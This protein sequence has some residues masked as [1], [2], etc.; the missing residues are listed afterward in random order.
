MM[1]D[2]KE[3]IDL[4]FQ[5]NAAEQLAGVDWD[6]LNTAIS[7]RLDETEHSKTSVRKH[8]TIFRIA[9]GIATA[10]IVLIAVIVGIN[11]PEGVK[12][13]NGRRAVVKFI[14]TK[15][16]A[17][18]E[19]KHAGGKGKAVVDIGPSRIKLVKC[20]VRI[21]DFNGKRPKTDQRPSWIIVK[22]AEPLFADNGANTDMVD[23]MCLF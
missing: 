11:R 7:S 14:E 12:L 18:V 15:G 3:K 16:S 8:A 1:K 19:I 5:Q 23:I 6:E 4:L 13:Q 20:D 9:A 22:R 21:I 17:L 2:E 10:A